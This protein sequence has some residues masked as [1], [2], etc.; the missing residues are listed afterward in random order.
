M[1]CGVGEYFEASARPPPA[2]GGR[3]GT[4]ERF[5]Y[6]V[7]VATSRRR[8]T[9]FAVH[10]GTL[11]AEVLQDFLGRLRAQVGRKTYAIIDPRLISDHRSLRTWLDDGGAGLVVHL[12]PT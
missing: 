3:A 5:E 10:N 1:S 2:S 11:D 7:L 12:L 6:G 8:Q 9:L 4:T